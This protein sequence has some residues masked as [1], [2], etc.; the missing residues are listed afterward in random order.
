M[1]FREKLGLMSIM[2]VE[3]NEEVLKLEA[4]YFRFL[5]RDL[6]IAR[7]GKEGLSLFEQM[8][9][10]IV[11]TDIK[12]PLMGGLEMSKA[13]KQIEPSTQIVVLSAFNETELL[14]KALELG[15]DHYLFKPF[16]RP[17]VLDAL[18]KSVEK[19]ESLRALQKAQAE[20]AQLLLAQSRVRALG[21]MT[22]MIAHQWR[23]PLNVL[24]LIIHN[25]RKAHEGLEPPEETIKDTDKALTIIEQMS[26]TIDDFRDFFKPDK[27][28]EVF[29]VD[30]ILTQSIEMLEPSLRKH[31]IEVEIL[32]CKQAWVEGYPSE[33]GQSLLVILQNAKDA[34]LLRT[35]DRRIWVR[36]QHSETEVRIQIED[37]G[38]GIDPSVILRIFEPYFSTKSAK[39]GM[40]IGLY[41]AKTIIEEH[42]NGTLSAANVGA[43]ACFSITLPIHQEVLK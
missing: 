16:E 18:R 28:R 24:G 25:I 37:N 9:P 43:G 12:M 6:I 3:D 35:G 39:H 32:T 15:V 11:I 2:I 33:L 27:E 29:A 21:E 17:I 14:I 30:G 41:M 20:R 4:D 22:S 1:A 26:K 8:R 13:I 31:A 10:E 34:L 7:N 23:Q 42:M 36:M 38:G 5:C 40:G 19:I